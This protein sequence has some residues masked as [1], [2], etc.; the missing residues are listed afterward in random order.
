MTDHDN[1]IS[2]KNSCTLKS[3]G[4]KNEI[5]GYVYYKEGEPKS[6]LRLH[7]YDK[8]PPF[9]GYY[10]ILAVGPLNKDNMYDWAIVSDRLNVL[11]FVLARDVDDFDKKYDKDIKKKVAEYGFKGFLKPIKTYQG[12]DCVY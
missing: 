7:F 12:K 3:S 9:D 2:V 5:E 4:V 6:K 8:G 10:Y 1:A 11:L